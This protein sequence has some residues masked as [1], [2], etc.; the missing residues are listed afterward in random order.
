M[1]TK[2]FNNLSEEKKDRIINAAIQEFSSVP[3]EKVSINKIIKQ[4]EISRGSFYMYFEDKYD[5][6]NYLFQ[7]TKEYMI[8]QTRNV[9]I[10]ASG[11]LIQIIIGM[12][13][14]LYDYYNNETYRNFFM[15]IM[16]FLQRNPNVDKACIQDHSNLMDEANQLYDLLD[17]C[18]FEHQTKEFILHTI[19]IAI[20]TLQSVILKTFRNQWS[21][22]K[23]NKYLQDKL[24]IL[25]NG[26]GRKQ[27]C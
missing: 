26:Y 10:S 6:T 14:M 25:Q 3:F 24:Y 7:V 4:A 8:K 15:N 18:Q 21:K 27:S 5:L 19:E 11:D 17:P 9:G 13:T 16:I 23:A 20:A 2:T 1:P 22:E 12:H